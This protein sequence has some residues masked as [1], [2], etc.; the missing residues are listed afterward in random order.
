MWRAWDRENRSRAQAKIHKI[1]KNTCT[2]HKICKKKNRRR[3][4]WQQ[5]Q[6]QQR[7][8][9]SD[10]YERQD[11]VPLSSSLLRSFL[12]RTFCLPGTWNER[13]KISW[14]GVVF[15][16]SVFERRYLMHAMILYHKQ[17]H[18]TWR[19]IILKSVLFIF[20][21]TKMHCAKMGCVVGCLNIIIWLI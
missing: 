12:L 3:R 6:Q 8:Q 14:F 1:P 13:I 11:E 16:L 4:Q 9:A 21:T 18:L 5:Q 2:T 20:C 17:N 19:Q 7:Q 15:L 10:S